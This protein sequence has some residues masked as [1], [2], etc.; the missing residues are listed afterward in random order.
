MTFSNSA[1]GA[2]NFISSPCATPDTLL[3]RKPRWVWKSMT[4]NRARGTRVAATFNM[5]RG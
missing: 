1:A 4:G 2:R 3:A 5:L